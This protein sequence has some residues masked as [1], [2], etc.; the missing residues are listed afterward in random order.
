VVETVRSRGGLYVNGR[1]PDATD[2]GAVLTGGGCRLSR[3]GAAVLVTPLP[4]DR[5]A[6]FEA[7]ICWPKLPWQ[8]PE[9]THVECLAEDGRMLVREPLRREGGLLVVTGDEKTFCC[10]LLK[11]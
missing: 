11:P 7:R 5:P 1:G 4:A 10:R 6:P 9:P 3:E 8:L 2:F